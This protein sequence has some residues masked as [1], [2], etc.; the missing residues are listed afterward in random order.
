M[1][2]P[3]QISTKNWIKIHGSRFNPEIINEIVK[4]A[5]VATVNDLKEMDEN[6]FKE[7]MKRYYFENKVIAIA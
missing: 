2:R 4:Y 1:I 3:P 5:S 7:I 6:K